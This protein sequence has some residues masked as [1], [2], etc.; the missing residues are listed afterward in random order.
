LKD[1]VHLS[2]LNEHLNLFLHLIGKPLLLLLL[3][4]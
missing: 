4:S 2:D 1:T 3:P